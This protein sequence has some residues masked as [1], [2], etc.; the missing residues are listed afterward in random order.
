MII[1][2]IYDM[3]S[4]N[5]HI[6]HLFHTLNITEHTPAFHL[7][8]NKAFLLSSVVCLNPIVVCQKVLKLQTKVN[9]VLR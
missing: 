2:T 7:I 9:L 3:S 1:K 8:D 5:Q 4:S 6:S